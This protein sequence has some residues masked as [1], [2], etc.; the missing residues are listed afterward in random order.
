MIKQ[1]LMKHVFFIYILTILNSVIYAQ[2]TV[3]QLDISNKRDGV[4]EKYFDKTKQLRYEGQFKHGKEVDTFKFYTLNNGK[5][6]L[7]ATKVF[8]NLD[9]SAQVKFLSSKGKRISE[10]QM[11]GMLY[12]GKWVYFHNNSAALLATEFYNLD[13]VLEG[14]KLVFYPDGTIAEKANYK[15]GKLN[16]SST[17][18]AE[19]GKV[20]KEFIFENDELN[21]V[22]KYY[23][24]SGNLEAEGVY[25]KDLKHGIWT[26]YENG[27][28]VKTKDHTKQSKNPNKQ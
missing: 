21:G 12:T 19:N 2:D 8:N 10:G 22:C 16:G 5:S 9:N 23:D 25:R 15:D 4:W 18:Y 28:L 20:L 14:E 11:N 26:Y 24:V 27:K 7:S 1:N 6:V 13:G 3:N 17:W